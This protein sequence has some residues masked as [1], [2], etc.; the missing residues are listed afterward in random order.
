[1]SFLNFVKD[2]FKNFR[3]YELA[4]LKAVESK[5]E[6]DARDIFNKH[7]ECVNKIQRLSKDKEVNMYFIKGGKAYFDDSLRF[8]LKSPDI[9]LATVILTPIEN[10]KKPLKAEIWMTMGQVF[11]ITFNK[12]PK[13]LNDQEIKIDS[14][15]IWENPMRS[16]P[17]EFSETS[18]EQLK[19]WLGKSENT[20]EIK[21]VKPPLSANKINQKLKSSDCIFPHDWLEMLKI[22]DGFLINKYNIYGLSEMRHV[23]SEDSEMVI[24]AEK[25]GVNSLAVNRTVNDGHIYYIDHCSDESKHTDQGSSFFDALKKCLN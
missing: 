23:I 2:L 16:E 6:S 5:L 24:L 18:P 3:D 14:I 22:S 21:N 20:F 9:K 8:P 25:E 19:Q 10:I 4:I 1:M 13:H 17:V 12:S 11:S 7:I 15:S